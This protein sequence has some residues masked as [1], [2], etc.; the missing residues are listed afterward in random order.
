V[1]GFVSDTPF[2]G[3]VLRV[4][5]QG[6]ITFPVSF[7]QA[8]TLVAP[9][10]DLS[11]QRYH[12]PLSMYHQT[13]LTGV[14]EGVEVFAVGVRLSL[15]AQDAIRDSP[16]IVIGQGLDFCFGRLHQNHLIDPAPF[17]WPCVASQPHRPD[18]TMPTVVCVPGGA[19]A[20]PP[21]PADPRKLTC[22][23]PTSALQSA[24][25]SSDQRMCNRGGKSLTGC[26]RC[27]C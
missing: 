19:T 16:R 7:R 2:E 23:P 4:R 14:P 5:S 9:L 22:T 8:S 20:S 25:S 11:G 17:M 13:A 24:P 1:L 3:A 27:V 6:D 21:R 26:G 18:I 15:S 10:T 12:F